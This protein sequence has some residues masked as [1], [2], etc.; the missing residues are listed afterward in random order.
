M[1]ALVKVKTLIVTI[2]FILGSKAFSQEIPMVPATIE[3]V[4]GIAIYND[5]KR[6]SL[7]IVTNKSQKG[8]L[9]A[10]KAHLDKKYELEES[11]KQEWM[12]C[13]NCN[14]LDISDKFISIHYKVEEEGK[15]AKITVILQDVMEAYVDNSNSPSIYNKMKK[16]MEN[17]VRDEYLKEVGTVYTKAQKANKTLMNEKS[18]LERQRVDIGK[19]INAAK[20]SIVE[21]KVKKENHLK[22]IEELKAKI[23][24][25]E[26]E[27]EQKNNSIESKS[28]ALVEVE[29]NIE[30]KKGEIN[31]QN[32]KIEKLNLLK[33]RLSPPSM[34]D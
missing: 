34:V 15:G 10:W 28:A 29:K 22:K 25:I 2:L 31:A 23:A 18:R 30:T 3:A 8:T 11:K 7:S 1:K 4:S 12:S 13:S 19:S 21:L 5:G 16:M 24:L 17:F 26:T 6:P 20:N 32:G 27:F 14:L 9:K 33:Q